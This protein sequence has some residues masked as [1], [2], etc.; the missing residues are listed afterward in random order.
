MERPGKEEKMK[1]KA[2]TGGQD[3]GGALKMK[4]PA[5]RYRYSARGE[6][7]STGRSEATLGEE[8]DH[9]CQ[10][11]MDS[12]HYRRRVQALQVLFEPESMHYLHPH[13]ATRVML[14]VTIAA[15]GKVVVVVVV[16]ASAR[17]KATD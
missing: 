8:Q 7:R 14:T 6:M 12:E 4:R 5:S 1:K 13:T 11:H 17:F 3:R 9:Q 2:T 10:V 15:M 16:G